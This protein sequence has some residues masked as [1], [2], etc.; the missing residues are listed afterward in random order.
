MWIS[1]S[2]DSSA[3]NYSELDFNW[4][5]VRGES[6]DRGAA[7]GGPDDQFWPSQRS[8]AKTPSWIEAV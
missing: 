7:D 8:G 1:L 4:S 5:M 3:P 2:L 6:S